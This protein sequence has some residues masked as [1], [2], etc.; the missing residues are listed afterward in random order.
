MAIAAPER[1]HARDAE[2]DEPKWT[3]SA[4][5]G[6]T[7]FAGEDDQPFFEISLARDFGDSWLEL[8]AAQVESGGDPVSAG[9]VP[10][11][12]RQL[13]LAGG[14]AFGA[15]SLQAYAAIGE[16]VFDDLEFARRDGRPVTIESDGSSL[17][18]GGSLT[19]DIPVGESSFF[20]PSAALDY[21][22]IDVARVANVPG[23][24]LFT[25]AEQEDGVT[26]TGS[27]SFQHLF[28][29]D[30]VH[31][32]GAYAA[33]V[34]SSNNAVYNPGSSPQALVNLF[35]FRDAPGQ[36]DSWAE[37]GISGSFGIG[38]RLRL[39]VVAIRTLGFAGPEATSLSA[40]FALSL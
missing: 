24:G 27:A 28:G 7:L 30:Y 17:G 32:L 11:T 13:A 34:H 35:A 36:E 19:V 8:S 39:N 6:A 38:R 33:F 40:G 31:N 3:V 14:T 5:G 15:V 18:I 29:D 2:S 16:R 37:L 1:T 25:I 22:E 10:A 4:S 21:A 9:F 12:T 26:I 20:S 23:A